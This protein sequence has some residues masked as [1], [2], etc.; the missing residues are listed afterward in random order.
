MV[1][2]LSSVGMKDL[3]VLGLI[4]WMYWQDSYLL[5]HRDLVL[6]LSLLEVVVGLL[7]CPKIMNEYEKVILH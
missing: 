4:L 7:S 6:H 1:K 5:T 3:M 2:A